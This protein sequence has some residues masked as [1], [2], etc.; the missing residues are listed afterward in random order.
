[1]HSS[2]LVSDYPGGIHGFNLLPIRITKKANEN[3][4]DFITKAE[5]ESAERFAGRP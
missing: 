1:V 4:Y 2:R 3:A 5:E